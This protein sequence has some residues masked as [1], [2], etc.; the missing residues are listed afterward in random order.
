[1][2]VVDDLGREVVREAVQGF[3]ADV[4]RG[5]ELTPDA[6]RGGAEPGKVPPPR[7]CI[8]EVLAANTYRAPEVGSGKESPEQTRLPSRERVF[9]Q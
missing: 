9:L 1:M 7:G 6:G 3:G 8:F 5:R 4:L 2:D